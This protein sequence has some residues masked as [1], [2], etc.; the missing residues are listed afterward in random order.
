MSET[1]ASQ[2]TDDPPHHVRE[3]AAE[4]QSLPTKANFRTLRSALQ[5]F[6]ERSPE[7]VDAPSRETPDSDS[8]DAIFLE[9]LPKCGAMYSKNLGRDSA[10]LK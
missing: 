2:K 4:L 8:L 1:L 10:I 7:S 6:P 5:R 9:L 3:V